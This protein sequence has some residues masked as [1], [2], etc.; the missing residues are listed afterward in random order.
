MKRMDLDEIM[1]AHRDYYGS[2]HHHKEAMAYGAATLYIGAAT[3]VVL[4][5]GELLG[6][7]DSR[8][9]ISMLLFFSFVVGHAFVIWQLVNR[10]VAANIVRAATTLLS[11][12]PCPKTPEP[13]TTATLW[14]GV[15]LPRVLVEEL[16]SSSRKG[17]FLGGART[18]S[19]L[20]V[21]AMLGWSLL[22]LWS[23]C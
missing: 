14:H 22:A 17:G 20:T 3:A 19:V 8:C 2:Y 5:G 18:A 21:V 7:G 9:V 15:E 10:E 4:K 1:A 23:L 12:L 13:D 16:S 11:R 6:T